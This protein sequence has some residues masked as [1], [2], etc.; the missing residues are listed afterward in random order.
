MKRIALVFLF[1]I[2][3]AQARELGHLRPLW[4]SHW[5]GHDWYLEDT[6]LTIIAN[7]PPAPDHDLTHRSFTL[8]DGS[9]I[10]GVYSTLRE[11]QQQGDAIAWARGQLK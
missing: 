11:G 5:Y 6:T 1:M 7:E 10:I 3:A 9:Q 4:L 2:S 8:S